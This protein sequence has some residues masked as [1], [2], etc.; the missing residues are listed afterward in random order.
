MSSCIYS[1]TD[2]F[3]LFYFNCQSQTFVATTYC[4]I[5]AELSAQLALPSPGLCPV[6]ER[7]FFLKS[8]LSF[9][10]FAN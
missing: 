7:G 9:S 3:S 1:N 6:A 5:K 2:F 10:F 4:S 8:T